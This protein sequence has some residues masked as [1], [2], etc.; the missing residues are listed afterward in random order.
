MS[1]VL[2]VY[3]IELHTTKPDLIRDLLMDFVKDLHIELEDIPESIVNMSMGT[4]RLAQKA[5]V[6]PQ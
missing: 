1:E 2:T 4:Y 3:R 6:K 5:E